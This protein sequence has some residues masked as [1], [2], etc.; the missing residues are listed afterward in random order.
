MAKIAGIKCI[1]TRHDRTWTIVKVETDQ[2]GLYGI[3]SA[4]DMYHP[5]AVEQ[6]IEELL[7]PLLIGREAGQ[8]EDIWQTMYTSGYWR[9]GAT[10]H[11]A[12]SGIDMAL[13]DI[14]GKQAGMPVYELLGGPARSEIRAYGHANGNTYEQLEEEVERYR[15]QGYSHIRV[16]LGGYGGGGFVAGGSSIFPP[17]NRFDEDLYVKAIPEMFEKL[18]VRY[19]M[20]LK[21]THDV[22]EH[23]NP[24]AAVALAKRLDPYHLFFLEDLLQVEHTEWYR[25]VRNVSTTP[26]AV[27]ELFVH[28]Q[29]WLPLVKERL[30][31]FVRMRVSKAGGITPCRKIAA[32]CEAFGVRTAWQEGG[33]NDPVNQVAAAHLDMAIWNFGVQESNHFNER[34]REVFPGMAVFEGGCLKL[35]G[36]PGLG[37]DID[38]EKALLLAEPALGKTYHRPYKLDRRPDGTLVRP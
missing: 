15:E 10:L 23:L 2:P 22:H 5:T 19:G 20:E 28:P 21:F 29:E 13:W 11:T 27:G 14:K 32:V 31:D 4:S 26:Q 38:E 6:V 9:N 3:G 8:I 1:R 34:E 16:Q 25:Q 33:E 37:I 7:A 12:M 35:S 18:R 17:A 36:K 24:A 30:I